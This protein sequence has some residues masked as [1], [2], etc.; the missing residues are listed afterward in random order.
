MIAPLGQDTLASY[1]GRLMIQA[2]FGFLYSVDS[3][4]ALSQTVN[5]E[6]THPVFLLIYA[7]KQTSQQQHLQSTCIVLPGHS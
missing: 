2:H 3:L 6:K 5:C 7:T 4:H 1:A